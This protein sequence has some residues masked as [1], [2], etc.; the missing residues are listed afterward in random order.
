MNVMYLVSLERL[1]D[2]GIIRSQVIDLICD[3]KHEAKTNGN[4]DVNII[5]VAI[6]SIIIIGRNGININTDVLKK[7]NKINVL[8]RKHNVKLVIIPFLIP[9]LKR[10]GPYLN[11]WLL[12]LFSLYCIPILY[13]L[14]RI[15]KIN[16]IHCRSYLSGL[17][18]TINYFI[19][20]DINIIFDPRGFLPEEGVEQ[21]L[22]KYKSITY[23]IWKYIEFNIIKYSKKTIALSTE[24]AKH[25]KSMNSDANVSVIYAG[26]DIDKYNVCFSD[27][28]KLRYELDLKDDKKVFIYV[29]S[30]GAW[31][32][33]EILAILFKAI[34]KFWKNSH[35]IVL[36]R[37]NKFSIEKIF[38]KYEVNKN[39][40]SVRQCSPEDVPKYL[41]ISN[42]GIIPG[43]MQVID[44]FALNLTNKTMIG[45]KVSEYLASGLPLIAR[46][47]IPALASIITNNRLG[48]VFEYDDNNNNIIINDIFSLED[49][50]Y[51]EMSYRCKTYA[52]N[53]MYLNVSAKKYMNVYIDLSRIS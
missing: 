33:P 45:L 11:I 40:Y 19:C 14:I 3:I 39:Y 25:I 12:S 28:D 50:S 23:N 15:H 47:D 5:L 4:N 31:N 16:I 26:V 10:W 42:Y 44:N 27:K 6:Q 38:N 30:L 29:G 46:K 2:N 48:F 20:K 43:R 49:K 17:L 32:S 8:L 35:L 7:S 1:L 37:Y 36:T 13:G 24:F 41:S 34:L 51:K 9:Q 18:A 22:W 53:N 52:K 21:N